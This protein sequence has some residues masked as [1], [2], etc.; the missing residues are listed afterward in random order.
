M[1]T[2]FIRAMEVALGQVFSG[3]FSVSNFGNVL[4]QIIKILSKISQTSDE[5]WS[6]LHTA[7][8][9]EYDRFWRMPLDEEFGPQIYKSNADL[10]NTGG[11]PGGS[12]T[13]ALFL[14]VCLREGFSGCF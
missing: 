8:E 4:Q 1:T 6:A 12:C 14:K 13:A 7:G 9:A 11:K 10:C 2:Y 5:L 3:V